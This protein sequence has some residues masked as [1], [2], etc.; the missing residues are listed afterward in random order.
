M[1][2]AN[3]VSREQFVEAMKD[4]RERPC[5]N[6]LFDPPTPLTDKVYYVFVYSPLLI[7]FLD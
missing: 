7:W 4:P 2:Y 3:Y 5:G 6:L 1:A